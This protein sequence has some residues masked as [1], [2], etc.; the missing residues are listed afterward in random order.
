[1]A[2]TQLSFTW[3]LRRDGNSGYV[4][5]SRS[6]GTSVEFGPMPAHTTPA[7]ARA[8]QRFVAMMMK[9]RGNPHVEDPLS[10]EELRLFQ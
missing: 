6:D 5:E 3:S 4:L 2:M 10:E 1:M 7:F 8:R 9:E